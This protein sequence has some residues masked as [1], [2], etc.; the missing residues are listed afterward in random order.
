[1]A[2]CKV[3]RKTRWPELVGVKGNIAVATIK[4]ENPSLNVFT[5]K[6]GT[7][8]T[9]EYRSD[10]VRVWVDGCGVVYVAPHIG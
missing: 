6:K 1:M 8:I 10:R 2:D 4:A 3:T 7:I 5:I 9:A